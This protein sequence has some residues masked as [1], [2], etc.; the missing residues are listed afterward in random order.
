MAGDGEKG[1]G[2]N[3]TVD[4]AEGHEGSEEEEEER[5]GG[6]R[7]AGQELQGVAG[8]QSEERADAEARN[9][10]T[11]SASQGEL[12]HK[13]LARANLYLL[14]NPTSQRP[15]FARE[16]VPPQPQQSP[17]R[18]PAAVGGALQARLWHEI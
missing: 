10:H 7:V 11:L 8:E 1:A 9:A 14:D 12:L 18:Y 3:T 16:R 15:V 13:E 6:G 2:G 4:R 17:V 5:G